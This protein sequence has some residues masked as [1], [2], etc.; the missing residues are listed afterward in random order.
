MISDIHRDARLVRE[1][2][3]PIK[4]H[5]TDPDY[6]EQIANLLAELS[7]GW[8][9]VQLKLMVGLGAAAASQMLNE[10]EPDDLRRDNN[11]YKRAIHIAKAFITSKGVPEEDAIK[12]AKYAINAILLHPTNDFKEPKFDESL[13]ET[14]VKAEYAVVAIFHGNKFKYVCEGSYDEAITHLKKHKSM[15]DHGKLNLL[16]LETGNWTEFNLDK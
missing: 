12:I 6:E 11:M 5:S 1:A 3:K 8:P 10:P 14:K 13:K 4:E 2:M 7:S 16:N 9:P 15:V